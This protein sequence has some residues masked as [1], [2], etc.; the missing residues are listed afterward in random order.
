MTGI[1]QATEEQRSWL[2][3]CYEHLRQI[4]A[5]YSAKMGWPK[6]IKLTTVKPSGTLSTLAGVTSGIHP[7]IY[8]Y[9]IRR[10]RMASDSPLIGVCKANGYHVE[11]QRNFD[12]TEDRNTMVVSFPCSYPIGT[13]LAKD[14]LLS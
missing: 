7:A 1:L 13:V 11:Y 9:F 3:D 2:S 5:E 10:I 6:S 8:Q 14:T 4:D 12:G